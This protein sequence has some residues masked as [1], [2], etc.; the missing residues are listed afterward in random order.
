MERQRSDASSTLT[1]VLE[2]EGAGAVQTARIFRDEHEFVR[3]DDADAENARRWETR[4]ARRYYDELHKEYAICDLSRWREGAVGLRWRTAAEVTSGKGE[5]ICAALGCDSRDGLRSFELPFEYAEQ[6]ETKRELVKVR[7]CRSCAKK[8]K[9][10]QSPSSSSDE[11]R[12][13]KKRKKQDKK[14]RTK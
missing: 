1:D 12:R 13:R 11:K 3:D 2:E 4:M 9:R 14:K 6:G 10:P 5:R 8:L 7:A